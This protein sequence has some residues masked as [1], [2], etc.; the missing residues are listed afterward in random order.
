ME[1]LRKILTMWK[2][3]EHIFSVMNK[4]WRFFIYVVHQFCQIT[5]HCMDRL[6]RS[7]SYLTK[8]HTLLFIFH[9]R[10]YIYGHVKSITYFLRNTFYIPVTIIHILVSAAL[11]W[12][13]GLWVEVCFLSLSQF[14]TREKRK[15]EKTPKILNHFSIIRPCNRYPHSFLSFYRD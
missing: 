9:G 2:H 14:A 3:I 4:K 6:I 10:I 11:V 12:L 1:T 7:M 5:W 8:L 13:S 15:D